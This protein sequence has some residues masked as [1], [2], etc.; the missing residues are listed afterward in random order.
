MSPRKIDTPHASPSGPTTAASRLAKIFQRNGYVRMQDPQRIAD[1][2][3]GQYKK[4][5]EVRLAASSAHELEQIRRLLR[6]AGFKPGCPFVKGKQYRQPIYGRE[7][8][9]RFLEMV[10][11]EA[12]VRPAQAG[13]GRRRADS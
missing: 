11:A 1:E 5:E 4:G 2:G 7:A 10:A 6:Q 12:G 13:A 3:W 9:A 8:V